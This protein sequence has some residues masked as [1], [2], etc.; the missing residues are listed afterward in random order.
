MESKDLNYNLEDACEIHTVEGEPK[1]AYISGD[2]FEREPIT[3]V[4]DDEGW[5]IFEGDIVLGRAEDVE[6]ESHMVTQYLDRVAAGETGLLAPTGIIV[7]SQRKR[8]PGGRIPFFIEDAMPNRERIELA[9]Q[10]WEAVTPVRFVPRTSRDRDYIHFRSSTKCSSSVG[11]VEGGQEIKLA[12]GC[13]WTAAVHEIG[14]A[15]GMSHEQR[16]T[17]RD[18]YIDIHEENIKP[19]ANGNF[20]PNRFGNNV[21]PYNYGSVMHYGN[22]TFS[23]DRRR[24]PTITT[25]PPGIPI[26]RRGNLNQGDLQ[27]IGLL[28]GGPNSETIALGNYQQTT[29]NQTYN[30]GVTKWYF[31]GKH[32]LYMRVR[33]GDAAF[34]QRC[35]AYIRNGQFSEPLTGDPDMVLG[36]GIPSP[37]FWYAFPAQNSTMTYFIGGQ[38]YNNKWLLDTGVHVLRE[39]YTNGLY[40]TFRFN[41]MPGNNDYNDFIIEVAVVAN[42][43]SLK[44]DAPL[45][46]A[47][48]SAD[49]SELL[50]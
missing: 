36:G 22:Y 39:R 48:V 40:Y 34:P 37:G 26:G 47:D 50:F 46:F 10:H 13:D 43:Q 5:A 31:N 16:R 28:L 6:K 15:F 25:R 23:R 41:D 35:L 30:P 45:G 38:Y 44:V 32:K 18:Q 42:P 17:D 24:L 2:D 3:Y 1:T 9:I 21:G 14:H 20:S 27:A 19:G 11:R 12:R 49:E 7:T 33:G 4:V 29:L 8:W